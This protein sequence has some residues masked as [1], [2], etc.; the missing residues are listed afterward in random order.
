VNDQNSQLLDLERSLRALAEADRHVA[1]PPHVEAAVMHTWDTVTPLAPH[2]RRRRTRRPLLLAIGS[3]AAAVV[4]V[5]VIY[6]GPSEPIRPKPI[7][8]VAEKSPVVRNLPPT[9]SDSLVEAP[10][11]R[12]RRPR[13]RDETA[14]PRRDRGLML[15]ADP[16]LDASAVSIVRVRVRRAA[17]VTLGIFAVEPNDSGW[18]DLEVLVG[19]DGVARRIRRAVPVSARE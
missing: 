6:R 9:Y 17:L 12:P 13:M 3:A 5:V 7:M 18:V 8:A 16:I 11:P 14:A 10:R 19:E 4:T 2:R 1:A 15:V